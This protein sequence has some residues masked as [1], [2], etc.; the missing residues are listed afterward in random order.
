MKNLEI[1]HENPALKAFLNL[2]KS[3][4]N[5]FSLVKNVPLELLDTVKKLL[6]ESFPERKFRVKYRGPRYDFSRGTCLKK[7]AKSAAIYFKY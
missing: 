7:H 3:P 4:E 2:M 5:E 1:K 6:K